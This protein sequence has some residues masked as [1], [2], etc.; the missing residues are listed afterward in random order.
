MTGP[1]DADPFV[2]ALCAGLDVEVLD[3]D[4]FDD[5]YPY[6]PFGDGGYVGGRT[7]GTIEL[8]EGRI[9]ILYQGK[10]LVMTPRRAGS[11]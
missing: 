2:V 1:L 4:A 3:L 9:A 6:C 10:M 5:R 8:P 7:I 11:A